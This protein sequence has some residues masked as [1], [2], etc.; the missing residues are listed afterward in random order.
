LKLYDV[1]RIDHF[2]GFEAYWSIPYGNKTAEN[3]EWVKGP[4]MK[5]FSAIKEEFGAINIIAED[6][7]LLTEETINFS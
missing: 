6:L 3:G 5:L 7:G 1:I 2:R 4:E